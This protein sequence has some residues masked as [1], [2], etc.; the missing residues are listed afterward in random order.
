[1]NEM[2]A[3]GIETTNDYNAVNLYAWDGVSIPTLSQWGMSV[4][5]LSLLAVGTLMVRRGRLR[6]RLVV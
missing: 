2:L 3:A 6:A 4:L 1:M 5:A